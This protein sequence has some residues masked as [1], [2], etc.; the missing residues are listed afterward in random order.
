M[1]LHRQADI[2]VHSQVGEQIGE[3]EGAADAKL[4]ASRRTE[5]CHRDA[6]DQHGAGR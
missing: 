1:G 3:L 2:L 4:G 6:V 5:L